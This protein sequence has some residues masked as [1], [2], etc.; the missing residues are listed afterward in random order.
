MVSVWIRAAAP[1]G[2]IV[3]ALHAIAQTASPVVVAHGAKIAVMVTQEM[4]SV[5]MEAAAPN[6]DIV[7]VLL[8]TASTVRYVGGFPSRAKLLFLPL[9][10]R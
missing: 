4:A 8:T 7:A 1:N 10:L 3:V 9:V 5:W 6:G 2:D